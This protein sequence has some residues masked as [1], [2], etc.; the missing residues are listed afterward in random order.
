MFP[1]QQIMFQCDKKRVKTEGILRDGTAAIELTTEHRRQTELLNTRTAL[2]AFGVCR[3]E[4]TRGHKTLEGCTD[5]MHRMSG[6]GVTNTWRNVN[7]GTLCCDLQTQRSVKVVCSWLLYSTCF[8]RTS[9]PAL[10]R[11]M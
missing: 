6:K 5:G 7:E 2:S 11:M 4:S 10:G 3:Q 8:C 1:T 9:T